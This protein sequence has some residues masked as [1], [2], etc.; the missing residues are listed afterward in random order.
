M[1]RVEGRRPSPCAR[2]ICD[3]CRPLARDLVVSAAPPERPRVAEPKDSSWV[4]APSSR[5]WRSA[6]LQNTCSSSMKILFGVDCSTIGRYPKP[7]LDTFTPQACPIPRL[8][9]AFH[10]SS[11]SH[12]STRADTAQ[13]YLTVPIASSFCPSQGLLRIDDSV[14]GTEASAVHAALQ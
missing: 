6:A 3:R 1:C 7:R 4:V 11:N 12:N 9:S 8:S 10:I 13:P 14:S 2:Q 5:Q